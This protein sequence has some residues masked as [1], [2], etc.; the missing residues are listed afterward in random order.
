MPLGGVQ[1]ISG[2]AHPPENPCLSQSLGSLGRMVK[3]M[4][5]CGPCGPRPL[6]TKW[7][8]QICDRVVVYDNNLNF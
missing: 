4:G 2:G 7:A 6:P 8:W 3:A 5:W 1:I